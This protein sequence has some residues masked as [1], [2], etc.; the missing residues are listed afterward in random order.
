MIMYVIYERPKDYPG[1]FVVRKWEI[2]PEGMSP[3]N[4]VMLAF[5]LLG[6]R[7]HVPPGRVKIERQADDDPVIVEV[8]I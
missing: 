7:L 5:T 2:S 6:A 8:W 1:K 4:E 3:V